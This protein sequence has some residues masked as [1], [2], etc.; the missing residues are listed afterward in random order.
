MWSNNNEGRNGVKTLT[1]TKTLISGNYAV[2]YGAKLSRPKVIPI[3]PITPQTTIV[4]KL[5]ELVDTGEIDAKIVHVESEHSAMAICV[6][7]TI[8]G[9]RTFTATSSHGLAL[10]HEVL[11]YAGFG[12]LPI[13]MVNV[14]RALAAPWTLA[15]DQTDG[16]AQRDTGWI[17][18]ECESN[19]EVL[20][21]I[22]QAHRVAEE[23][24]LPCMV[25][26]D[27]FYISHAYE[28]IDIP[29]IELVDSYLPPF[30]PPEKYRL[31]SGLALCYCST[32]A[33]QSFYYEFRYRVQKAMERVPEAFAKAEE[34]FDKLFG[35]RY[36]AVEGYYTD[37]AEL[38]IAVAGSMTG[39][40]RMVVEDFR[41]NGKKVGM[42]KVKMFR[43]FPKEDMQRF[44][45]GVPKVAVFD[46]N[47]SMGDAGILA[48]GIR[49]ALYDVDKRPAIFGFIVGLGG[50]D[51][52]PN[53]IGDIIDYALQQDAPKEDIIWTEVM[54]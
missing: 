52:T 1:S 7:A 51:I 8:A 47:I 16:L 28:P 10:M 42:L 34:D 25:N 43:P 11:F 39:M 21:T 26:M 32:A 9:A 17:L 49:S 41:R 54:R 14:H 40:V 46:R 38:V 22:I 27:G 33:D 53:I 45:S 30:N 2:A 15:T 36:H 37:D 6:G 31:G 44:L 5:A 35:R 48:Q 24:M 20:D 19:Q 18:L 3:Y 23:V 29:D 13:V 12:R 4:E 50:A